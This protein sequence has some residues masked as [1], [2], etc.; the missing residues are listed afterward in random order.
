MNDCRYLGNCGL[1]ECDVF[2]KCD[3]KGNCKATRWFKT[4][5]EPCE[6]YSPMPDVDDLAKVARMIEGLADAQPSTIAG[7]CMA[8]SL[9]GIARRIRED[10]GVSE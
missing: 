1:I 2:D 6:Y 9:E 7:V 3:G 5:D 8:R 4:V 10:L